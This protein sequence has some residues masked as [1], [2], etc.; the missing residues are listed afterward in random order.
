MAT[1]KRFFNTPPTISSPKI[2][3]NNGG[4][5]DA[6]GSNYYEGLKEVFTGPANRIERYNQFDHIDRDPVVNTS[7]NTIAE[8][9]TQENEFTK[10]PF[11]IRYIDESNEV[12]TEVLKNMLNKWIYTN[13]FRK[14]MYYIFRNLIKYGDQFFVRDPETYEWHYIDPRN[15][16]K[17]VVNDEDGKKIHSY[18]VKNISLNLSQ[19]VMTHDT[20]KQNQNYTGM[21]PNTM[22]GRTT[23]AAGASTTADNT[24][25]HSESVEILAKH[26]VHISLNSTGLDYINWP[27]SASLLDSV[28]KPAKQKELL[29][30]AYMIYRV[31]RAPERR[32]FF[33]PTGDMPNHKAMSYVERVK[34]EMHQKRIPSRSSSNNN[35][36]MADATYNP[37]NILQDFY[38]PVNSEGVGPRVEVLPGGEALSSGVDDLLHFNNE[39]M[40]GLGIPSSYIPTT[41]EDSNAIFN[42]GKVGTAFITEWRFGQYC[43]RLQALI[44]D[45]FDYEFKL[46]CKKSGVTISSGD[47]SLEFEEPQ[48]FSEYRQMEKDT[49]MLNVLSQ[50]LGIPYLSRQFALKRFGMFTEEE[51]VQNERLWAQENKD[52]LDG[53]MAGMDVDGDSQ[54]GL[55]DVGITPDNSDF[56]VDMPDLEGDMEMPEMGDEASPEGGE[57]EMPEEPTT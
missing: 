30:D 49:Q 37:Q 40:R 51:I 4:G 56:E 35:V 29:Q 10:C 57:G 5:F 50:A 33:I 41:G 25:G 1:W 42:D 36:S 2:G 48:S 44:R 6:D 13:D 7:L 15:V 12:E 52:K 31:Q 19:K 9:S 23:Q 11:W 26:V 32:M 24:H 20:S 16:E 27:F 46:F 45:E 14:R 54:V 47:F 8:F 17:I 34:N 43:K 28:Y 18:F 21:I 22:T 38:F 39:L 53:S 3:G 55:R